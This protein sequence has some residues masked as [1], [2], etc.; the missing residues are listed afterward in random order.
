[1]RYHEADT[2]WVD[3]RNANAIVIDLS[4]QGTSNDSSQTAI[5][6][7]VYLLEHGAL[8]CKQHGYAVN[9]LRRHLS[10]YHSYS[11]RI[12]HIVLSHFSTIP[13]L[14]PEDV[15]LPTPRCA[16]FSCLLP[17]QSALLCGEDCCGTISIS[18]PTMAQHCNRIHGW[19]STPGEREHWS[20]VRVQTFSQVHGKQR[21]FIVQDDDEQ[22]AEIE[23]NIIPAGQ[24][25]VD[26]IIEEFDRLDS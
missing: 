3:R 21:Y 5:D 14:Q 1:M 23:E 20:H 15:S 26:E 7:F 9:G 13:L 22:G 16:P 25:D 19:R 4:L 8:V 12:K 10:L 24:S 17:P 6:D 18:R 11:R 2:R